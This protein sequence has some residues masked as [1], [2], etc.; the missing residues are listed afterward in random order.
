MKN[1]FWGDGPGKTPFIITTR[2][3]QCLIYLHREK[4]FLQKRGDRGWLEP[5]IIRPQEEEFAAALDKYMHLHLAVLMQGSIYHLIGQPD[6][7]GR[8]EERLIF[9]E[10]G[11]TCNNLL[12]AADAKGGLHLVYSATDPKTERWWLQHHYFNGTRWQEP[13]VVDFGRAAAGS[14]DCLAADQTGDLHLIYRIEDGDSTRLY[15]RHFFQQT[16]NWEAAFPASAYGRPCMP[17]LIIDRQHNLHLIW[18]AQREQQHFVNYRQ[19]IAGG[20]PVGGWKEIEILSPPLDRPPFPLLDCEEGIIS[21]G[22]L[23][24]G[25]LWRFTLT[26]EGWRETIGGQEIPDYRLL[27]SCRPLDDWESLPITTWVVGKGSPPAL[28][29][30]TATTPMPAGWEPYFKQLDSYSRDLVQQVSELSVAGDHLERALEAKQKEIFWVS[31]QS[32]KKMG[33]LTKSLQQKDQELQVL[34][35][36]LQQALS[37]LKQ[38]T[39]QSHRQWEEEKKRYQSKISQLEK[40]HQQLQKMLL[41]KENTIVKEKARI[42][43]LN[44]GLEQLQKENQV[45]KEHLEKPL[46]G[47]KKWLGKIFQTRP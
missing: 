12:L 28:E 7:D 20:W 29:L 32:Q 21:A 15:Y 8:F 27:R 11:R 41:E 42:K 10:E 23:G 35:E 9:H 46:P 39:E 14:P 33:A 43:E 18:R 24:D 37:G 40:E 16:L 3:K 2:E 38:K 6:I 47:I 17:G 5:Q 36:K 25:K 44:Q 45:L 30:A 1:V 19:F 26:T 31:Q 13:R 4:L 22:W 34:E